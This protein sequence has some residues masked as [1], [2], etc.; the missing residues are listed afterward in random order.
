MLLKIFRV[1]WFLSVMILFVVLLYGYA[2]WQENMIIQDNPGEQITMSR[3]M[4]FY[5][6]LLLV[7]VVNLMVYLV[8][9]MYRSAEHFR[10]WFH[11]L[12]IVV[13]IFFVIAINLLGLYNS[14][15]KYDYGRLGF[16][17]YGSVTLI[18]LWAIAWP[19][20]VLIQKFLPKQ[21][22]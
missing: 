2:G 18:V 4:L 9:K 11:G 7:V 20:Y 22:V 6:M 12:V 21:A 8:A 15:E 13:N 14:N 3:E 1:V 10:A 19:I 5:A 17:I 16:I